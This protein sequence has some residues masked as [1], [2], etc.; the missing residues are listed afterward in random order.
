LEPCIRAVLALARSIEVARDEVPK[1][2]A[3]PTGAD[4]FRD[5]THTALSLHDQAELE[6][7]Q[8]AE[9]K[10]NRNVIL[11]PASMIIAL[12]AYLVTMFV[13]GMPLVFLL[14]AL[15]A[16]LFGG[17]V[18][19]VVLSTIGSVTGITKAL[20]KARVRALITE[21]DRS[22]NDPSRREG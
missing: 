3:L 12:A 1:L 2:R 4:G 6:L 5:V 8:L 17:I 16:G 13:V 11:V 21:R 19:Y 14:L 22:P 9:M 7:A 20:G 18:L 10:K 15:P